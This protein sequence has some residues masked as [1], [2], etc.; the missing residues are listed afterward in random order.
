MGQI[1]TS[2][3]VYDRL[4][5]NRYR[6][7]IENLGV[8]TLDF[9]NMYYHHLVGFHYLTDALKFS[10]PIGGTARFYSDLK[11]GK[12]RSDVAEKSSFYPIIQERVETFTTLEEILQPGD[13]KVIVDF[14]P[15]LC[16]SKIKAEFYLYKREGSCLTGGNITFYNLF[17]G[18]DKPGKLYPC[19]YLVEHSN[20]YMLQQTILN[21]RIEI[22]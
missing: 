2:L 1:E 12:L 18:I 22:E 10:R 8:Y 19:T 9:A 7:N 20:R 3:Q 16:Q 4:K 21:C 5:R 13:A 6:I 15:S 14:D 17:L 11:R